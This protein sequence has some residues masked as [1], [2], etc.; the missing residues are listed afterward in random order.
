[1]ANN[2]IINS[3]YNYYLTTYAPKTD[4]KFDTH[5]KSE[6]RGV[7]NSIV[8]MNKEAPLYIVD[9]SQETKEYAVGLKENARA[10]HNTIASLGGVSDEDLLNKKVAASSDDTLVGVKYIGEDNSG[11][12]VE[13][14]DIEV[15]SL[16]KPQTNVGN[17]LPSD[18]ILL[19]VDTYSFDV[20]I[21]GLNYEFQYN[22]TPDDTNRTIQGKLSRLITNANIGLQAEVAEDGNGNSALVIKSTNTG[23]PSSGGHMFNITDD[24][25][26]KTQGSVG[27]FGLGNIIE[28]SSNSNFII[29]GNEF[30]SASN[31]FTIDKKYEV[32]LKRISASDADVAHVSL[33]EDVESV[34]ANIE[35]LINGYNAFV[36]T[37]DRYAEKHPKSG[38]LVNEMATIASLRSEELAA[39]GIKLGE[40]GRIFLD[41]D[42]LMT[43][44]E[45]GNLSDKLSVLKQFAGSMLRKADQVA[46]NPMHYADRTI[47]AYKNPGHNFATP[48]VTSGYTGMLFN[49]YC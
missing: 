39:I 35:E 21:N 18:S 31:R 30:Q 26:S 29:N 28:E 15:L 44:A 22:V 3:V 48:Y 8:K 45:D 13:P 46:L 40:D 43:S 36:D 6:L 14:M 37:A 11:Q 1:M 49:S 38:R 10:F 41:K 42:A 12:G 24:S 32:E 5:K 19:P 2:S 20:G 17:M 27:Y 7:Y 16:A 34:A 33:K 23:V 47:V 4:S 25:T 9:K